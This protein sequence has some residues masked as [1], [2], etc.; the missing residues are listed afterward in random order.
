MSENHDAV[1]PGIHPPLLL[2]VML[3]TILLHK[4]FALP[5]ALPKPARRAGILL[6]ALGL[7]TGASAVRAQMKAGTTPNPNHPAKAIVQSGPYRF[8]RNPMYLSMTALFAGA[9]LL[10]NAAWTLLLLPVMVLA[11][12]L[13]MIRR[14]EAYLEQKFGKDYLRYKNRVHR[15]L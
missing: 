13:G 4:A 1:G 7:L 3:G 15:W 14:E 10:A 6:I 5:S 9:A 2:G 12:D 8:T 11:L